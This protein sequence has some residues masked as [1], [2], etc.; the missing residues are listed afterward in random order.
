MDREIC[1]HTR[2]HVGN[3]ALSIEGSSVRI[4][5]MGTGPFAVP[6]CRRL[7]EA[8]HEIA[9][10]VV[11]PPANAK[12]PQAP[13]EAWAIEQGL[14]L[15]QPSSIN[16]PEALERL[17]SLEADLFFVCDY[18]QIL[19]KECLSITRLGGI[20]LHGSLLPRHRGAAPVQWSILAGDQR[21]GVS[22]IH[23]TPGLDAGPVLSVRATDILP[24]ENAGELEVRLSQIGSDATIEAVNLL[25]S[26]DGAAVIGTIQDKS[27]ATKAPRINKS[28]GRLDFAQ[29]AIELERKV[30]GYQPWPGAF[31]ELVYSDSKRIQIHLRAARAM[32]IAFA[33]PVGAAWATTAAEL[34]Q[35]G[36]HW[37]APWDMVIAIQTGSGILVVSQ[38]QPAGKRIMSV[39]EYLRGHPLTHAA[40][41]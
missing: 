12:A 5:V 20:N 17:S 35:S 34:G 26:W 16:L 28:D 11:R 14:N 23:M 36:A 40:C 18:G 8:G 4:V 41:F 3:S 38:V 39:A 19:S 2:R 7:V 32:D 25:T 13:V 10:V 31:G 37:S 29:P 24:D 27:Q 9:L 33:K 22:V 15:Y 1:Y 21:A 6:S 30:R